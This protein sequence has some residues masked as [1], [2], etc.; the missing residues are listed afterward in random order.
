MKELNTEIVAAVT[1][2]L[3]SPSRDKTWKHNSP[4]PCVRVLPLNYNSGYYL[5]A[6][7]YLLQFSFIYP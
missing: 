2:A 3:K 4:I 1:D 5:H 6:V 7:Y